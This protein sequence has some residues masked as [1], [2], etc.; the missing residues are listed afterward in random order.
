[1]ILGF[2]QNAEPLHSMSGKTVINI[3]K[4]AAVVLGLLVIPMYVSPLEHGNPGLEQKTITEYLFTDPV[5]LA[6]GHYH[7]NGNGWIST[8]VEIVCEI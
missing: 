6:L 8:V 5:W 3:A 1:M 2:V 7:R 4:N